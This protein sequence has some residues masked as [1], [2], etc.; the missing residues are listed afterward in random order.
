MRFR[1]KVVLVTGGAS[2]LGEATARRFA[3]EGAKLVI[4]DINTEGAERVAASL[5]DA[6][7]VTVDTGDATSVERGIAEAVGRYGRL[8]VVFN[9]AGI[10]G[11]QQALHEMDLAN[12]EKV[13][14]I[15][16]D[17]V[18]YVLRYAIDAMLRTG[19]GAIVNTSSTAGLTAQ[20][21]I[22]PYTFT[23][24]GIVGLT[25][26]A[27]V[28]YAAR[29]IR[30]NAVAPTVV[31]TPLVEHFIENAPDPEQMRRQMESFNPKPGIPTADD[32]AGVVL[33]LASDDAAWVTGH[34]IPIDGGYVAR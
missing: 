19:G 2:G 14:R 17:G 15:N 29:G 3:A 8:D 7:A 13:R 20:D 33:F 28:E 34:T 5:P 9:N 24:A 22:S 11:Q 27:A 23:K 32:V 1:D 10:D 25:R 30:V 4:A 6:L 18:F 21:N 16:G 12:W 31:M 26:S